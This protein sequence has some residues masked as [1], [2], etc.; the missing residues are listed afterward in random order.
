MIDHS[1]KTPVVISVNLSD[2]GIPKTPQPEVDVE[3]SGILGDEHDHKKHYK[4]T[5]ALSLFDE[6]RMHELCEEGYELV[7]G[8]IGENITFR[9]LHVQEMQPGTILEMGEVIIRLEE[10]RKPCYVLDAVDDRL[11]DEIVG[12]C[13]YMASVVQEGKLTPGTL[14]VVREPI[15]QV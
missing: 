9:H 2:G 5:R 12:R 8:A 7:P 1:E 13:G 6:E 11:K 10:P 15:H 4:L 3:T 14:V